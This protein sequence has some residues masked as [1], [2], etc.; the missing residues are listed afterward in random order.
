MTSTVVSGK[1]TKWS[2][3]DNCAIWGG[4]AAPPWQGDAVFHIPWLY[5]V[6]GASGGGTRFQTVVQSMVTDAAGTTTISKGPLARLRAERRGGDLSR[7]TIPLTPAR[8]LILLLMAAPVMSLPA[9]A[10]STT[11]TKTMSQAT[12]SSTI[13]A[14]VNGALAEYDRTRVPDALRNAADQLVRDD[15]VVPADPGAALQQGRTRLKLW[16]AIM[17]RFKRDLDAD[18]DPANPPSSRQPALVIN[19][20]EQPPWIEPKDL[21]DPAERKQAEDQIA[22]HNRRVAQFSGMFKLDAV[23]QT[24]L[25]HAVDSLRNARDTL[26]LSAAEIAATVQKADIAPR[27]KVALAAGVAG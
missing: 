19:G 21:K 24:V 14:D 18:F 10:Q 2:F 3:M 25:A 5:R 27:D 13:E 6:V 26:G 7:S 23:H 11:E 1:G 22:A 20:Q 16:I 17:F 4:A 12:S 8:F 15:G 9:H